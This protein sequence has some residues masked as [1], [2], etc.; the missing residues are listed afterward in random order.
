[1]KIE[2]WSEGFAVT[3]QSAPAE[4][5]GIEEADNFDQAVEQYMEKHPKR[6]DVREHNGKKIYT[7]WGCLLFDNESDARKSFG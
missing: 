6:I 5:L 1:M 7:D 3:G 4:L 2:I